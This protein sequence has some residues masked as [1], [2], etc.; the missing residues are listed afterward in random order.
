MKFVHL[1]DPRA[2]KGGITLAYEIENAEHKIVITLGASYCARD[3][4]Y[5]KAIGRG[6]SR[7]RLR[8]QPLVIK[9]DY[10]E[11]FEPLKISRML[12]MFYGVLISHKDS[13][14][15]ETLALRP[16]RF[17]RGYRS[18]VIGPDGGLLDVSI[19]GGEKG[20]VH[21]HGRGVH[22]WLS[23]TPAWVAPYLATHL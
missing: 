17:P 19:D 15:Q 1:F 5:S 9:V 7:S 20:V 14:W 12:S 23:S 11:N 21:I 3:E 13:V 18:G 8:C 4:P 6:V 2:P 22:G 10:P 16:S